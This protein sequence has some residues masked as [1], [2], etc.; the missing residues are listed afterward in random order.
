MPKYLLAH[1]LGTSGNKATLFTTRGA[2][3]KSKTYR[4]STRFAGQGRAEQNPEDWWKA[5][6]TTTRELAAEVGAYGEVRESLATMENG[7]CRE[8]LERRYLL[9]QTWEEIAEGM[10]Y[11]Y[12]HVTKLHG[13]ALRQFAPVAGKGEG[14]PDTQAH[15]RTRTR[16]GEE[17]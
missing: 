9:G 17:V 14:N 11:S 1:D 2:R 12:R 5:V 8:V 16:E 7:V 10:H 6:V 13:W 3:I 15:V 4:Y